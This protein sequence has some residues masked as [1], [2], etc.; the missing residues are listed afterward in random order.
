[1]IPNA[2]VNVVISKKYLCRLLYQPSNNEI[3]TGRILMTI[4]FGP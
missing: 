1:M 4:H 3:I 2:K